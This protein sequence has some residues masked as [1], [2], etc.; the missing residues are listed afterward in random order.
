MIPVFSHQFLDF[1]KNFCANDNEKIFFW[2][3]LFKKPNKY[4]KQKRF[5][6]E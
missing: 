5:E 3:A 2:Q 6:K 4:E 1:L